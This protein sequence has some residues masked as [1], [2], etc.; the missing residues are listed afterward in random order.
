MK[1]ILF[2]IGFLFLLSCETNT[3][4]AEKEIELGPY[5]IDTLLLS[6]LEFNFVE[7]HIIYKNNIILMILHFD[8]G[9]GWI[10]CYDKKTFEKKWSW[11]EA[12]DTYGAPARGFVNNS[13][14]KDGILCIK[15]QNISYG[16]NAETGETLWENREASGQSSFKSGSSDL[17]GAIDFDGMFNDR[18][19]AEAANINDGVWKHYFFFDKE[20]TLSVTGGAPHPFFWKGKDYLA[21]VT[22][23]WTASA[24]TRINRLNLY[25]ITDEQLEWTSDTIPLYHPLSGTPG[26]QPEFE[27][28]QILLANDAIYSY[29]FEDGSLEWWKRYTNRFVFT[30]HLTTANGMV[31]GNNEDQFMVGLDVHTGEEIFKTDTGGSASRIVY[32]NG[33]CY[34]SSV[35]VGGSNR[36]MVIDGTTGA[37]LQSEKAPFR[38]EDSKYTFEGS[39]TVDPE[40][41]Y[42]YTSDHRYLLIY[43]FG[44]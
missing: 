40:T 35:T 19:I 44:E 29:N 30:T 21:F 33:K 4:P 27:D 20:D 38:S 1:N 3:T 41:E 32:N 12:L 28:G 23:K 15:Q 22:T 17:I 42:V 31:Y 18:Y 25:N 2:L 11:Q 13:Y 26:V 24:Q 16:I 37:V 8:T 5:L 36:L 14:L 43:D 7:S 9:E 6:D 10:D 34:M 39:L